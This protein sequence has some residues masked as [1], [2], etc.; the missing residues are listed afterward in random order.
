MPWVAAVAT[1][2][3]SLI[4]SDA[5]RSAANKAADAQKG[6]AAQGMDEQGREFDLVQKLL[7]PYTQAGTKGIGA[8]QDLIGLNGN[9]AQQ[10]AING[11]QSSP[12]FTSALKLGENRMLANASATGGLRGG[13]LQAAISQ[14]SPQLLS[15]MINDQFSRLGGFTSLGENAAAG[16][17]N[18]GMATGNNITQLLGQQGAA[19][20][21][22]ALAGGRATSQ[23]TNGI[24]SGLGAYMSQPSTSS[25]SSGGGF[26]GGILGGGSTGGGAGGSSGFMSGSFSGGS[27]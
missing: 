25:S 14:F 11:I 26:L 20:A 19:G 6:A 8:Q 1:V 15:Q 13:N 21:G 22:A 5:S 9:D 17:G 2:V 27:F 23:L 12:Q 3:G 16:V 24:V 10:K 4:S 18:A 7:E